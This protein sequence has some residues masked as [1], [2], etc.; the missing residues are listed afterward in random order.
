MVATEARQPAGEAEETNVGGNTSEPPAQ[1]SEAITINHDS[2]SEAPAATTKEVA[3]A[4]GITAQ[5]EEGGETTSKPGERESTNADDAD[6]GG[7]TGGHNDDVPK[8]DEG[9]LV[10]PLVATDITLITCRAGEKVTG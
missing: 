10:L 8:G 6:E 2:R 9:E 4:A 7:G 1:P 3:E 5:T